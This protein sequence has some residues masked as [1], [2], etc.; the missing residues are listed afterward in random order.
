MD[1]AYRTKKCFVPQI[2]RMPLWT[3]LFRFPWE[4]RKWSS[5]DLG[6]CYWWSWLM[7]DLRREPR[8]RRPV[9]LVNMYQR[10]VL[11]LA[12]WSSGSQNRGAAISMEDEIWCNIS[13]FNWS[14]AVAH[15]TALTWCYTFYQPIEPCKFFNWA[16][17]Q[18]QL[19]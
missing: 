5:T 13:F 15:C 18:K 3:N 17:N 9:I 14:S 10:Q 2:N 8:M 4:H 11:N 1:I 6:E 7:T 12:Q 16:K 19:K